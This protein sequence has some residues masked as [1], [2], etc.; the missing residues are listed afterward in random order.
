M[1]PKNM[2]MHGTTMLS[3]CRLAGRG[4]HVISNIVLESEDIMLYINTSVTSYSIDNNIVVSIEAK[5]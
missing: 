1:Q 5:R 3:I 2:R 4:S